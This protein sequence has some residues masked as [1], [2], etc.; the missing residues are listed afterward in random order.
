[1]NMTIQ[2]ILVVIFLTIMLT[3]CNKDNANEVDKLVTDSDTTQNNAK[4]EVQKSTSITESK[5]AL[6]DAIN[7]LN[8]VAEEFHWRDTYLLIEESQEA[9]SEGDF[10]L[11][12]DLSQK[13]IQQTKL[14]NEQQEF[15]NNNWQSL[16]P[17]KKNK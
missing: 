6:I 3:N 5:E 4:K 12:V 13:V 15:A 14:M 11:S 2:K 9:L 10:E 17:K 8:D 16:I 7:A 1:M